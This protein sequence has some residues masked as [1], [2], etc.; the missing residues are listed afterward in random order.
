MSQEPDAALI[1]LRAFALRAARLAASGLSGIENCLG[2]HLPLAVQQA[3]DV[4]TAEDALAPLGEAAEQL[5]L[6]QD[7]PQSL[8]DHAAELVALTAS[9]GA[10]FDALGPL[11]RALDEAADSTT[12]LSANDKARL[13]QAT[14]ELRRSFFDTALAEI[15]EFGAPRIRIALYALGI[16][17]IDDIE[18]P[19][20]GYILTTQ[21]FDLD[22]L[23]A[24]I[25]DPGRVLGAPVGWGTSRFDP[26]PLFR[27]I[28]GLAGERSMLH[29]REPDT[30]PAVLDTGAIEVI[31]NDS[32]PLPGLT[33]LYDDAARLT[34]AG[35]FG[36]GGDWRLTRTASADLEGEVE[37]TVAP[38]FRLAL[39]GAA[40]ARAG[41]ELALERED[42]A[43]PLRLFGMPED[44]VAMWIEAPR[45]AARVDLSAD[46][47]GQTGAEP[48]F[49]AALG[50]LTL[51]V[52]AGEGDGFLNTVLGDVT[53]EPVF[54]LI[55]GWS[56]G[57][58]LQLS[59]SGGLDVSVALDKELGPV[60]LDTVDLALNL[61]S[62]D[63]VLRLDA[64]L[65]LGVR[66]GPIAA[67]VERIG[68]SLV[69]QQ[70]QAEDAAPM[71]V[72]AKF[73]PPR[74][75]GM[76]LNAG[77]AKGGGFL[78]FDPERGR[79]A[80]ALEIA[81][82]EIGIAAVGL[83]TT[84]EDGFSL[85]VILSGTFPPIQLGFGFTLDAL[86]GL[87]GI[88]RT[89]D[90][91]FLREGLRSQ[92]LDNLMFP[93]DPVARAPEILRDIEGAFPQQ[94]GQH[95][96]GP[97]VRLGWGTPT[98]VAAELGLALE[99]DSPLRLILLGK[100]RAG[101][102]SLEIEPQ[103][104]RINMDVLGIVDFDREEA[105]LD[106]VLYDSRIALYALEGDMA[107][108]LRWG[109]SPFFILSIGGVHSA[110]E[111][112][113]ELPDL[114]RLAISL[115]QGDNPRIRLEAFVALSSNTVQFGAAVDACASAMGFTAEAR[116]GFEALFE[117]DP[118]SFQ[119][120]LFAHA[121]L[122]RGGTSLLTVSLDLRLTGPAPYV[123][124]GKATAR[125]LL[126]DVDVPFNATFGEAR[127]TALPPGDPLAALIAALTRPANWSADLPEASDRHVR[128]AGATDG[129]IHPLGRLA[130]RQQI[131]PLD[132]TID[133][134]GAM[135][136]GEARHFRIDAVH[137]RLGQDN[138]RLAAD[139]ITRLTEPFA[140]A[141]FF[142]MSNDQRLSAPSFEPM[143]AGIGGFGATGYHLPFVGPT[144][145]QRAGIL[146][147]ASR[148]T[149][150]VHSARQDA[151]SPVEVELM[152]AGTR[153]ERRAS[154]ARPGFGM[155]EPRYAIATKRGLRRIRASGN[156]D[157]ADIPELDSPEA[158]RFW[159]ARRAL[160]AH[161]ARHPGDAGR[162]QVV[163][164]HELEAAA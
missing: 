129:A 154:D 19:D 46:S 163:A 23:G 50:G 151:A 145:G 74:G 33:L 102:P 17:R 55:A 144:A 77:P 105:S 72:A 68:T 130:V 150:Y 22:A 21:R 28:E 18:H 104:A 64:G 84:R 31:R 109:A 26:L 124:T 63:A 53:L 122:K 127:R 115:G 132:I 106:A 159:A 119:A 78:S 66:I 158:H 25:G 112:P 110:F 59:G 148:Q 114:R 8:E 111:K 135:S 107:M 87:V 13:K 52:S 120:A 133:R 152:S 30:G 83:L 149:L 123:L 44:A 4:T 90:V 54:D 95:V 75:L 139:E 12:S 81:I 91:D 100:L 94:R 141:Q 56:P 126:L 2:V 47:T 86:G 29:L 9:L 34:D 58:G 6:R 117:L 15:F 103:I 136:P 45:L 61:G 96:F 164:E 62:P 3:P 24:V 36:L 35:W 93:Q 138:A 125:I 73:L 88:N 14:A 48:S 162:L 157:F 79:Y 142:E 161:L 65:G 27:L 49:E 137:V 5:A 143:T 76:A 116:L 7:I 32:A 156:A 85:V 16:L 108:R 43:G 89:V 42:G 113:P 11:G 155:A 92:A 147:D 140:P 71:S 39:S 40:S 118:F 134:F 131:L 82:G 70:E 69:L 146:R 101:L 1:A 20:F 51:K 41:I 10:V 128:L 97:M 38:P 80:G 57:K 60:R 37:L 67:T 153:A 99:L 160:D 121:A 98:L